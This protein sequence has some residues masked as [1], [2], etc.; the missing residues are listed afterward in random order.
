MN[1][2]GVKEI[3]FIGIGGIAMSAAAGLAKDL[4]Y[5]V[6]GSDSKEIY[7]PAK[8]VL[9]KFAIPYNIGYDI[10][11]IREAQADLYIV[12]AGEDSNNPEVNYL[13][14]QETPL[15]SF[16]ELLGELA[17][18]KIRIVVAGTNGKSTTTGL[19]GHVMSDIDDSSFMT[20]AVLQQYE[21][22][23]HSGT[24]HY[25]I[26]EGDEYKVL[27]NDPTPKFH[28]YKPDTLILTNLEYDHPDMY[29]SL[30]EVKDEFRLLI[31]NLPDDGLIIYNAD[32]AHLA[33][34]VHESNVASFSYGIAN[35]ADYKVSD[36]IF[37][38]KS[39]SFTINNEK[40]EKPEEYSIMLAGQ[41]N[42]YNALGPIALLR[43]L[44]FQRDQIYPL[45][46]TYW[47]VK[48]RLEHIG[49]KNN[50]HVYDDYAHFPTA[51]HET[52]AATRSRYPKSRIVA[53]F[54][55]HTYSRT[56]ATLAELATSFQL[57]D[58]AII[59]EVYP[60]R[61]RKRPESITGQQVVNAIEANHP[62]VKLVK[63]KIRA[64]E[65]LKKEL[66]TGDVVI[67]MAVGSFNTLAYELIENL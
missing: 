62:N 20:G 43:S 59:A 60:A 55:P 30:E 63:D 39:T 67:V 35:P 3:Y 24:G 22:N 33:Q 6:S 21:S 16:S 23:F 65:L 37:N 27:A 4:G 26:F 41:L 14:S 8:D 53:I 64:L 25:F 32:D 56:E 36:I 18:D 66:K 45:V 28:Y 44:G 11:H 38:Q 13:E 15:H 57:A 2:D 61:E 10:K 48:R 19:L 1:L 47:G 34:L 5:Q 46:E 9:D 40:W 17:K 42:I 12:S 52:L 50:I 29:G 31:A 58:M 49:E 54:E 51:I 7:A